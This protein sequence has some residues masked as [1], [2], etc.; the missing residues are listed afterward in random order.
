[1]PESSPAEILSTQQVQQAR[2]RLAPLA[3]NLFVEGVP[4]RE[5]SQPISKEQIGRA[6][7]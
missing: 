4:I 2:L 6:H 7:V 3:L 1:M 5:D